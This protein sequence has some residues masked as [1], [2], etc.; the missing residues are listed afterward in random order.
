MYSIAHTMYCIFAVYMQ[1]T[2]NLYTIS[3]NL[4]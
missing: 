2:I 1:T 4:I 3:K